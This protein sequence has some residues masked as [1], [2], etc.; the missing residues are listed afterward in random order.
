L[1]EEE[2]ASLDGDNLVVFNYLNLAWETTVTVFTLASWSNRPNNS[3]N[4]LTSSDAVHSAASGVKLT[5][6]AYKMLK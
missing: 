1:P 2:G 3:F 4:I 6:S 5:M